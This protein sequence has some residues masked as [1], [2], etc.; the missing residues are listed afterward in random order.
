[1]C[2][3]GNVLRADSNFA[4]SD[5]RQNISSMTLRASRENRVIVTRNCLQ[6]PSFLILVLKQMTVV[7][8]DQVIRDS[9]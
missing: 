8:L 5:I 7:E 4:D 9:H 2:G 1:M 3:S 6:C